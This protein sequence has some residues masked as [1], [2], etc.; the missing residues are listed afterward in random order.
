MG[1]PEYDKAYYKK[2]KDK[3]KARRAELRSNWSAEQWAEHRA[4]NARRQEK[5]REVHGDKHREGYQREWWLSKTYGLTRVEWLTL[6]DSQGYRCAICNTDDFG[7]KPHTDHDHLTGA[8]RGILCHRCNLALGNVRD[9]V[10][11]LERMIAYL[12]SHRKSGI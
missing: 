6:L 8:V 10:D 9:S 5:Y 3:Q 2:N 4:R 11:V 7:A 12:L 1:Y